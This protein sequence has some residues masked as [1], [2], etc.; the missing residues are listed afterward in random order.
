MGVLTVRLFSDMS[1]RV[2]EDA[3]SFFDFLNDRG[4]GSIESERSFSQSR[5]QSYNTQL[6]NRLEDELELDL[7]EN[8]IISKNGN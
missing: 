6:Y 7:N 2:T 1:F 5:F 3:S 8:K 4:N